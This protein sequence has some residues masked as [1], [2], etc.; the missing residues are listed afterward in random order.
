LVLAVFV[1]LGMGS[2]EI[3]EEERAAREAERAELQAVLDAYL[4]RMAG[5][6]SQIRTLTTNAPQVQACDVPSMMTRAENTEH[7]QL[8]IRIAYGPFLDRFGS[9]DRGVWADDG[10]EW[11]FMTDP[12]YRGHFAAHPED[13]ET[14]AVQ[15]TAERVA[16]TFLTE[17]Y[18]AVIEPGEGC[19]LPRVNEDGGDTDFTGGQCRAWVFVVDQIDGSIACQNQ[20]LFESSDSMWAG[21]DDFQDELQEDYENALEDALQ[22]VLPPRS[23]STP[24]GGLF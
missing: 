18:L 19:S 8:H 23:L 4:T 21:E 15:D 7:N 24:L 10:G 1:V 6:R 16:E 13:R 2:G 22:R 12:T 11:A 14:Y 5:V 20:I 17:R 3:T 9:D